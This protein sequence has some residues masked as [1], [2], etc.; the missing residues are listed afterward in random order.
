MQADWRSQFVH[1]EGRVRA[2]QGTD[3]VESSSLDVSRA[4]RRMSSGTGVLTS[5]FQAASGAPGAASVRPGPAGA[6]RP[7]TIRAERLDYFDEGRKASYHGNVE[8]RTEN[9]TLRADHMDVFFS[10]VPS[11][12]ASEIERALGDGHVAVTQPLRHA[13][14]DHADYEA[15]SGK[16][17]MTGGPPTLDDAEKGSTTGQRL[18]FFVRDD[19]LIVDGG[20]QSPSLSQ[21]RV[22]P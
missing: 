16:I 7:V 15:A 10:N 9:T 3:V 20:E 5:H 17:E 4:Q 1:Y 13:A 12:Q 6:T 8:L 14:G 11:G 21:H 22:A 2:W 19:K 18:T